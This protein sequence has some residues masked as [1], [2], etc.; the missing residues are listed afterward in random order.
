MKSTTEETTTCPQCG[1][2]CQGPR[3]R[4]HN[5]AARQAHPERYLSPNLPR[6]AANSGNNER[7]SATSAPAPGTLSP[8][9]GTLA[10]RPHGGE[11]AAE[12]QDGI[13]GAQ[14]TVQWEK[15]IRGESEQ[16]LFGAMMIL[17]MARLKSDSTRGVAPKSGSPATKGTG[18]KAWLQKHAPSVAEGTAFR[19]MKAA[20]GLMKR[21][22]IDVADRLQSLLET[23]ADDL[24][25]PERLKQGELFDL[26][27]GTSQAELLRGDGNAERDR[28]ALKALT[29]AQVLAEKI[30]EARRGAVAIMNCEL[31]KDATWKLME[32][33]VIAATAAL[34][35]DE[36]KKMRAWLAAPPSK[37]A[38]HEFSKL[39]KKG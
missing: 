14:L 34:F 22:G 17:L 15:A 21:A 11:I 2:V 7:Q 35:E 8:F 23:P 16:H 25:E 33:P 4:P 6:P 30:E 12:D 39:L 31:V 26:I 9:G 27:A 10:A 20:K 24:P 28:A 37:R 18:M 29:P 36:A 32:E 1:L 3:I 5:C 19:W 13:M 38:A